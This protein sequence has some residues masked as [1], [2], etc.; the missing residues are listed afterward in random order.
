MKYYF[1]SYNFKQSATVFGF[2]NSVMEIKSGVFRHREV[3]KY[4]NEK[5]NSKCAIL[6]YCECTKEEYEATLV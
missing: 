1:V 5:N 6:F 4:L 3:E 2:G